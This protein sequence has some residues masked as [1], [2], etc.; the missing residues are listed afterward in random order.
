MSQIQK[1]KVPNELAR[2][3]SPKLAMFKIMIMKK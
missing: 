2:R 1:G 3:N